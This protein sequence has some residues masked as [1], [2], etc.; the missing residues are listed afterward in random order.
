MAD[1]I[2]FMPDVLARICT[3]VRADVAAR[4]A[5]RGIDALR[6]EIAARA[7]CDPRFWLRAEAGRRRPAT[8]G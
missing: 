4:K 5:K 2:G 7:R 3:E 6:Q 1:D 8:T